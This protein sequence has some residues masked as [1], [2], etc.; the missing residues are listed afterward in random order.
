MK[1]FPRLRGKTS[2]RRVFLAIATVFES[3]LIALALGLGWL[4]SVDPLRD[5]HLTWE[6]LWY[7]IVGTFPLHLAFQW[8]YRSRA[9]RMRSIQRFLMENLGPLLAACRP[10][11]LT[12]LGF[13]AGISEEI[14]F[15]GFFQNWFEANWDWF[16][17]LFFSNLIF[18]I[19]HWI[20]PL[21][22]L[23]AGLTGV[24]LGLAFG[25]SGDRNLLIPV[26]IHSL[27]DVM[28]FFAIANSYR[29][30]SLPPV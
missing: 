22:A 24:Y 6:G 10:L 5:F 15:R 26:L 7:G 16:G 2:E 20:T 19:A 14:L 4:V 23:L 27:Y 28:A 29:R 17:G 8:F 21:Y 25:L 9:Q 1:P 12:Y 13:L 18:A 11:H 3:A 30:E